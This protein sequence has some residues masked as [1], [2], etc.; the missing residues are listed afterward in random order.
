[1]GV[2]FGSRD[3]VICYFVTSN[4]GHLQKRDSGAASDPFQLQV[5][6][7]IAK[8]GAVKYRKTLP[9][10]F[11]YSSV[12]A[13]KEGNLIVRTGNLLRLYAADF[14][15]VSAERTLPSSGEYDEWTLRMSPSGTTL[16]LDHYSPAGSEAEIL[17]AL[18]LS[19][20]VRVRGTRPRLFPTFSMSDKSVIRPDSESKNIL[21]RTFDGPWSS[22]P[23]ALSC[24]S[25]PVF[26]DDKRVLDACGHEVVVLK[27]NGDILLRD[28][29]EKKEHLE[30]L[31]SSTLEGRLAAVSAMQTTGGFADYGS[32]RRSRTTVLIYDVEL[33]RRIV[34]VPVVPIPKQD[35]DFAL[36]PD[37]SSIAVMSDN[38]MKLY[39]IHE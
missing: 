4:A 5:V 6:S 23:A 27:V 28:P 29:I 24:V 11:G 13:N 37:G 7:F 34:S 15:N 10:H 22:V 18:S 17:S 25:N 19:T 2:I 32:V 16:L 36:A 30:Q 35:Y 21:I 8:N 20:L 12:F 14:S 1:M 9:A 3:E 31:T 26:L 33:G 39:A 38:S